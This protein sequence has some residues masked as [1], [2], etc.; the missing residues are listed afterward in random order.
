TTFLWASLMT[1]AL[2]GCKKWD[3]HNQV[4]NQDL[5]K[6][7]SD[8]I[9]QR[10]NLSKFYG[11]LKTTGLDKEISSS[12]TYTVWAPTNDALQSLDPAIVADSAKLRQFVANHIANQSYY[13]GSAQTELRVPVLNGKRV[14][15]LNKKYDDAN[16]TEA[17]VTVGNG[18]LHV[19]D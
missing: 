18:V 2:A 4:D 7:L 9:S 16:L 1:L 6:T 15:F 8:E 10:S 13:T 3:E 12:K 11:Y 17:D 14:S 19:L 5:T